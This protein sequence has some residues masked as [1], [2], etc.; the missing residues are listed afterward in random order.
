[1]QVRVVGVVEEKPLP[2]RL[3]PLH[4]R[5]GRGGHGLPKVL[6]G[7]AMPDPSTPCGRATPK[8]A[9]WPFQG[10][11]T[12]KVG[13]LW[14]F[15]TLLDTPR[16]TPMSTFAHPKVRVEGQTAGMATVRQT[17]LRNKTTNE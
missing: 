15:P 6:P 10:W 8:T 17:M 13:G 1:M 9:L 4:G 3:P 12:C 5:M 11:P 2:R 16:R 7:P 14:Q